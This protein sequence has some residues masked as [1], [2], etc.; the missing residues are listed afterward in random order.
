M[1]YRFSQAE[2]IGEIVRR[3][4]LRK[5]ARQVDFTAQSGMPVLVF[6]P[7]GWERA[8]TAVG[9]IDF[10][11]DD[12]TAGRFEMVTAAGDPV[13]VQTLKEEE[14]FWMETLKANRKRRVHIAFPAR[15]PA[16]GYTSYF[17]RPAAEKP[18]QAAMDEAAVE[19]GWG[20]SAAGAENRW[21]A[22]AITPDGGIDVTDKIS[23]R[24]YPGLGHFEDC[25]D[26]GDE[27]SFCPLPDSAPLS[28]RGTSAQVRQVAAGPNVAVYEIRR[29]MRVPEGLAADR[30]QRSQNWVE[31]AIRSRVT[32]YRHTP[33]V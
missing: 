10:D 6:N 9:E 28:T 24:T 23:G 33:G 21:L 20:F 22:F 31:I 16:C 1:E 2:Q 12:E 11:F 27:Y 8:E 29:A 17:I 32:L 4:N 13:P 3:D 14:L 19:D 7:L 15:A 5:L 25:A 18:A 30:S 26:A